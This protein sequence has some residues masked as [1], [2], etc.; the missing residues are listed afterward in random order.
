MTFAEKRGISFGREC[1]YDGFKSFM[2]M[3]CWVAAK[4]QPAFAGCFDAVAAW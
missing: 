1:K 3:S 4:Q 2:K